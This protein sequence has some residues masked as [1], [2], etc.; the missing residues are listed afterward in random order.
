MS[1]H[2]GPTVWCTS[3]SGFS[4]ASSYQNNGTKLTQIY[5]YV[6]TGLCDPI[7]LT[8]GIIQTFINLYFI[9]VYLNPKEISIE[10]P[11]EKSS[12]MKPPV[13]VAYMQTKPLPAETGMTPKEKVPRTSAEV[14]VVN[15]GLAPLHLENI[16]TD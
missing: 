7:T 10:S 5:S 3:S 8:C 6:S 1:S 4:G 2:L 13:P 15:M 9:F 12:V 11:P 16:A 14:A